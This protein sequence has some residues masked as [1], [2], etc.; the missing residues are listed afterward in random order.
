MHRLKLSLLS[1]AAIMLM[2]VAPAPE[3]PAAPEPRYV[4][5]AGD[6]VAILRFRL[7][8]VARNRPRALQGISPTSVRGL[9]WFRLARAI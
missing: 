7:S 6:S 2:G 1:A 3:P 4:G 5:P 9:T 8:G